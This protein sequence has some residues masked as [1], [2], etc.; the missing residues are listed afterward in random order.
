MQRPQPSGRTTTD[1]DGCYLFTPDDAQELAILPRGLILGQGG[2][3]VVTFEAGNTVTLRNLSEGVV[4]PFR[5]RAVLA[6]GTTAGD[7]LGVF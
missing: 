4:Y 2:D 6:T 1:G 5:V 7:I 3:L